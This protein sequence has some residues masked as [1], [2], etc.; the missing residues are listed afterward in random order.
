MSETVALDYV[1]S[2]SPQAHTTSR[3]L[4]HLDHLQRR[5]RR[6]R[7]C[8]SDG[9]KENSRSGLRCIKRH[10]SRYSIKTFSPDLVAADLAL[11]SCEEHEKPL[12]RLLKTQQVSIGK[13]ELL[14]LSDTKFKTNLHKVNAENEQD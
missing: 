14:G 6:R 7:S 2:V 12:Q 11:S 10:R 8:D 1:V 3:F 9:K 5:R 13:P 4:S